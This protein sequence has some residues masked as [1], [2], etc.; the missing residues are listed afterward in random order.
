MKQF[1]ILLD[2]WSFKVVSVF[3]GIV[4]IALV[5]IINI[6]VLARYVFHA[7]IGGFEELPVF[8]MIISVWI[9]AAFVAKKDN[10][11]KIEF[12]DL[13]VKNKRILAL[14]KVLLKL[15]TVVILVVFTFIAFKYV[16]ITLLMG[17]ITPGL[18][19]PLWCLQ[20]IIPVSTTLMS[21]FY[22]IQ[23]VYDFIG[24]VKW[25]Y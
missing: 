20:G 18:H 24:V 11:I 7:S 1:F 17:D 9:A 23:T 19:I 6:Q 10:H 12:L 5:V 4:M 14:I 8:L 13:M 21:L 16:A 15:L 22:G 25:Q 2:E 3:L